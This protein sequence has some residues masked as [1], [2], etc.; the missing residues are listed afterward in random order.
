MILLYMYFMFVIC[1]PVALWSILI[2]CIYYSSTSSLFNIMIGACCH[3]VPQN[4]YRF[5]HYVH[6][7]YYFGLSYNTRDF[8]GNFVDF[9]VH[10]LA[11]TFPLPQKVIL[12]IYSQTIYSENVSQ[13]TRSLMLILCRNNTKYHSNFVLLYFYEYLQ[14]L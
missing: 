14:H 8:G 7:N 11:S 6:W 9:T 5:P 13:Y 4:N 1:I 3:W 2:K 12:I 10:K